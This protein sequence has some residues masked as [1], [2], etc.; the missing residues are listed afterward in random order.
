MI[1]HSLASALVVSFV[2]ALSAA[3]PESDLKV[4]LLL[5][6][7]RIW[8]GDP[9]KPE[10]A[11][12]AIDNGRIVFVKTAE[13][14]NQF[15]QRGLRVAADR[16]L[17]VG[18]KRVVP[19]FYDAHVHLLGTGMRLGQ[20]R[21]KDAKD[22]A[23]FGR[24]LQEFD[25]SLPRDRW[26]LGGNWDHDRALGGVLP[27]AAL[28]D[29]YVK[30]RP[31]FLN[32][33]DGHMGV[34]NSL[35]LKEAG[36]TAKTGEV[37]G[38]VIYRKPGSDEPTGLLRDA[39]MSLMDRAIP[40]P[41]DAE[42]AEAVR[43]ALAV[44]RQSGLTS[45]EDM[46]GSGTTTRHKLF[47]QYQWLARE[48]KLT[49]RIDLRWPILSWHELADVGLNANFGG[50][51]LRIGGVKAFIDGSLGSST[52]KFYEPYLNEPSSTGIFVTP[53]A[54]LEPMVRNVDH[55]GLSIAVHCI[56]DRGNAEMLRIYANTI[57]ANGARDRRFRIEHADRK[58][59]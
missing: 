34:A 22:E 31:V 54:L 29:K 32:R 35:A 20:V 12:L 36:V 44:I 47:Q 51:W 41:D 5:V 11:V 55:A 26:M 23:E 57:Q 53:L 8:T 37:I 50:D 10:A 56:G 27:T 24:R 42:I 2:V 15:E 21:L 45:V 33:Y 59:T 49:C 1:R 7:G 16:V 48:G 6:N 19:G 3:E 14:W 9:A 18:G 46:D 39:A 13:E 40:P 30:D 58:S 25:R 28:I 52:A 43:R 4:N 38:G 17:D